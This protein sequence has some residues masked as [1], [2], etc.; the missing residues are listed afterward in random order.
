MG[1]PP[2]RK[3]H[4]SR[5]HDSGKGTARQMISF[6][7]EAKDDPDSLV[8]D[9]AGECARCPREQL[10]QKLRKLSS[11]AG[12][13]SALEWATRWGTDLERAYAS[14][15][16]LADEEEIQAV[17]NVCLGGKVVS[18]AIRGHPPALAVAGLLNWDDPEVRL[19]GYRKT[20]RKLGINLYATYERLYC[21]GAEQRPPKDFLVEAAEAAG[22]GALK[23]EHKSPSPVKLRL[24]FAGGQSFEA[25]ESC[26]SSEGSFARAYASR[27]CERKPLS[28]ATFEFALEPECKGCAGGCKSRASAP[29]ESRTVKLYLDGRLTDAKLMEGARPALLANLEAGTIIAGGK[30]LG[31]GTARL[32]EAL[33]ADG[34]E[35][36]ALEV[37]L[38]GLDRP[39]LVDSLTTNKVLAAVWAERGE[40]VLRDAG[41]EGAV[42]LFDPADGQPMNTVKQAAGKA[43]KATMNAALP[44][45]CTLGQCG[46]LADAVAREYKHGG[47]SAACEF[48]DRQQTLVALA[49]YIAMG[50]EANR[51]WKFGREETDLGKSLAPMAKSMLVS[52]GDAYDTALRQLLRMSGSGEDPS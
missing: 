31:K 17:A 23:C 7:R 44:T 43:R 46:S 12:N 39:L 1:L 49:F 16:I 28:D 38:D 4:K 33:G 26:A 9:C 25:C 37:A 35:R 27:S 21:T 51:L 13:R 19:L 30:C 20:A 36:K 32:L 22:Y 40:A 50:Q 10:L 45:Y 41:G 5:I 47:Q 48:L 2:M 34:L 11:L 14:L 24:S 6:A 8:P 42:G 15:V 3:R 29:V 52:S 18:Y